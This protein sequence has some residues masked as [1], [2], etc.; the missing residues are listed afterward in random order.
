MSDEMKKI[1]QEDKIR[2]AGVCKGHYNPTRAECSKMCMKLMVES[3]KEL[4]FKRKKDATKQV[5]DKT[6]T[7]EIVENESKL[8]GV[9]KALYK[10][11]WGRMEDG[12]D[13]YKIEV[14][15]DIEYR[16]YYIGSENKCIVQLSLNGDLFIKTD[17]FSE[18][19]E[20]LKDKDVAKEMIKKIFKACNLKLRI[21]KRT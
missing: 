2:L 17:L 6:T 14:K 1:S 5:K 13:N 8:V 7:S 21:R 3:C 20:T 15:E 19:I 9:K 12:F 11:F 10:Y 4:T 16:Y 18:K